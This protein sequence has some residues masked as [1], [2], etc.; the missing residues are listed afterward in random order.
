MKSEM[1]RLFIIGAASALGAVAAP[2]GSPAADGSDVARC[3]IVSARGIAGDGTVPCSDAIQRLIDANPNREIFFPDGTYLLDKPVC[4]PA[5]PNKSVSLRLSA[6]AKFKAVPGWTNT[7][8]MVRLG[9]IHPANNIM[10]P[11]SWYW[12][13][14]GII[15]GSGVANG[16]S[17]DSGRETL[18]ADCSMKGVRIGLHIKHGANSGSSDS[19]IRNVNIV[20]NNAPDSIGVLVDGYDNTL[21]NMRIYAVAKGVVINSG[22]NCLRDIHPLLAM[23]KEHDFYSRSV[24]FEINSANNWM[25]FCYSDQ[26]AT[27]FKFGKNGGGVLDK[28]FCYWYLSKPW[29]RHVGFSSVGQFRARVQSPTVVFRNGDATNCLVEVG[30]PGGGGSLRDVNFNP[31]RVNDPRDARALYLR[32]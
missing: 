28:C 2:A 20:G 27:G 10:L 3:A 6:Y 7:E 25:D 21:A 19:D 4:T 1:K 31:K 30:A 5:H 32:D 15:D 26:F 22:G 23:K 8:A 18:V 13:K 14:G 12:L 17:I 16:I 29:M 24:G 11:G 9:G